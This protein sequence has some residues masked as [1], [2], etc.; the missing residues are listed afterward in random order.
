MRLRIAGVQIVDEDGNRL[1]RVAWRF[2]RL[3]SHASELKN[4]AIVKRSERVSRFGR[5]AEINRRAYTVAQ[6]QVP[7]YEISVEMRQKNVLDLEYVLGGKRNVLVRVALRIN[8]RC[9]ACRFV[10]NQIGSV[11]QTRQ[12]ELLKNQ[13]CTILACGRLL[14]LGNNPKIRPRSLPAIG[15]LLLGV[16]IRNAAAD[17]DIVARFPVHRC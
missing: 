14:R 15:V 12:V 2:Q 6:F 7:G 9:R 8:D 5:R 4:V 3:Q 17:D 13:A 1:R 16:V 11:R 10:S